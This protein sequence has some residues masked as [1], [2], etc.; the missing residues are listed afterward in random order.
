ML[1]LCRKPKSWPRSLFSIPFAIQCLEGMRS[2]AYSGQCKQFAARVKVLSLSPPSNSLYTDVRCYA[3][4]QWNYELRHGHFK[5]GMVTLCPEQAAMLMY[6]HSSYTCSLSSHYAI[7]SI[8]LLNCLPFGLPMSK[9]LK[10]S[11]WWFQTQ[12]H[13]QSLLCVRPTNA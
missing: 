5:R 9:W 12:R 8:I 7:D 6:R 2:C 1:R 3:P 10:K 13:S 11:W 4:T